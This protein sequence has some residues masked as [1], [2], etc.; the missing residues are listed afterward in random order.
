M[1]E[2]IMARRNAARRLPNVIFSIPL[3]IASIPDFLD[4]PCPGG[5][6]TNRWI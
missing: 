1:A 2:D 6:W 3:F 5:A 4:H